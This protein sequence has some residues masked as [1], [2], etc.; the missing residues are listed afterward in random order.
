MSGRSSATDSDADKE[1]ILNWSR[2]WLRTYGVQ[3]DDILMRQQGDYRSDVEVKKEFLGLS[4]KENVIRVWDD[5]AQVV[6]YWRS[7]GLDVRVCDPNDPINGG[8][9]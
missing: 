6:T 2:D 9:F 1:F 4:G 7:E 8:H 5:R 3:Y